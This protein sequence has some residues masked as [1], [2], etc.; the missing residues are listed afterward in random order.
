MFFD[1]NENDSINNI[2]LILD[3]NSCVNLFRIY[4]FCSIYADCYTTSCL[5]VL[6]LLANN[7]P[8]RNNVTV[9]V[10][11]RCMHVNQIYSTTFEFVAYLI[12]YS[13]KTT[14]QPPCWL[15]SRS[16]QW[17][18]MC[19]TA[20]VLHEWETCVQRNPVHSKRR[21]NAFD[22]HPTWLVSYTPCNEALSTHE[23]NKDG[24]N[25]T[26]FPVLYV[27]R[28]S[29][30]SCALHYLCKAYTPPHQSAFL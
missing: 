14:F 5:K 7:L 28:L 24:C 20:V 27:R 15:R 22:R 6:M 26:V 1:R 18:L 13:P 10:M 2:K 3:Y 12:K 30:A 4:F 21:H 23:R 29:F 8:T 19:T 25:F 16:S 9:R 11:C 17:L